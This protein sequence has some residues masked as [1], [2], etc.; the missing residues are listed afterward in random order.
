MPQADAPTEPVAKSAGTFF[1]LN[2]DG[3]IVLARD[4]IANEVK[5]ISLPVA[6]NRRWD[7]NR[8]TTLY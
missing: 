5:V 6:V 3:E 7:K 8:P 1:D 4:S 2:K